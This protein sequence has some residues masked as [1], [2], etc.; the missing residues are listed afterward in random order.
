LIVTIEEGDRTRLQQVRKALVDWGAQEILTCRIGVSDVLIV[1]GGS[2][3]LA[4]RARSLP[5]VT[6]V[7]FPLEGNPLADRRNFA[8]DTVVEVGSAAIGSRR[9]TVLAGPCAV[10]SREQLRDSAAAVMSGGATVLRGGAFKP[11][12][13][14]YSFQGTRWEGVKLLADV[15]RAVGL[16]VVSEVVDPRDVELM[17]GYVDMLQIGT[18][19]A[20]NYAL[21]MEAGQA[22]MPVLLK[23]GFGCSV[24]EWLGAAEYILR[25]GNGAVVLCERG[26]RTFE[27]ATRFT[28]DLA[29]IPVIKQ[30]S[31][32]PVVVDPSHGTG[33]R[34]LVVPMALAAAAAGADGVLVDVHT[35][36]PDARCDG[37]QALSARDF[38]RLTHRLR[39]IMPGLGRSLPYPADVQTTEMNGAAGRVP[40]DAKQ[41][42]WSRSAGK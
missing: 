26:I 10:E 31:H 23:R 11:R 29:A 37:D 15:G 1:H 18:R 5:G 30:R 39:L 32:L 35:A 22:R 17:A 34:D 14:P 25:Q 28:L 36:A 2:D 9:F 40:R 8:A 21:L 4:D 27:P 16:P 19:N 12:T 38:H 24:E 42:G 3:Q 13:S 20:Q 33:N 41:T 7:V 6:R